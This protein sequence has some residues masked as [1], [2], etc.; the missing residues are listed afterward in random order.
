MKSNYDMFTLLVTESYEN[1]EKQ[2]FVE[3]IGIDF[4]FESPVHYTSYMDRKD[5]IP[6]FFKGWE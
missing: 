1:Q 4:T 3:S 2:R 6:A 5:T